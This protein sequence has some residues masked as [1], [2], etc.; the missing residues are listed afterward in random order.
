M[1]TERIECEHCP[2]VH[3][4]AFMN[5]RSRKQKAIDAMRAEH[6]F[7]RGEALPFSERDGSVNGLWCIRSGYVKLSYTYGN[8]TRPIRICG[9]GDLVGYGHWHC[10][11]RFVAEALEAVSACLLEKERFDVMQRESPELN[12]TLVK[13]ACQRELQTAQRLAILQ[14][15]SVR[16]RVAGTLTSL[17]RKFGERGARGSRIPVRIDRKTL[18]SLSGTVPETLARVLS[19]F[20]GNGWILRDGWTIY[21]NDADALN[22]LAHEP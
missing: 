2:S 8:L 7:T 17:E 10:D 15:R 13:L 1:S 22:A 19:E 21:V 9:P 12:A 3:L 18:A 5:V 14:S 20:E 11:H 16:S 4:S 6:L